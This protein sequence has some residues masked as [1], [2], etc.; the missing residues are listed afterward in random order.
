MDLLYEGTQADGVRILA[1]A[2][3]F[4]L[5]GNP[6]LADC[7]DKI[8]LRLGAPLRKMRNIEI[9]DGTQEI[10]LTP[11]VFIRRIAITTPAG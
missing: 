5:K 1:T 11:P 4:H 2:A 6:L 8:N 3:V 10:A 9:D 7:Q